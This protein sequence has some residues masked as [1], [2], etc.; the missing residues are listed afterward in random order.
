MACVERAQMKS[1]ALLLVLDRKVAAELL[2]RAGTEPMPRLCNMMPHAFGHIGSELALH[3]LLH[4]LLLS[5]FRL[6]RACRRSAVI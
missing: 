6:I 1:L 4:F 5:E 3:A 2:T